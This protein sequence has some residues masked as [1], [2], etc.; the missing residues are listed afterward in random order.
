MDYLKSQLVAVVG[1]FDGDHPRQEVDGR[2]QVQI[3]ILIWL[4]G[5][6]FGEKNGRTTS[7][8]VCSEPEASTGAFDHVSAI[9]T[10]PIT[11]IAMIFQRSMPRFSFQS[12]SH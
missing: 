5:D 12:S 11:G 3:S 1:P 7:E 9:L 10:L 2:Y 8:K 4:C 6:E